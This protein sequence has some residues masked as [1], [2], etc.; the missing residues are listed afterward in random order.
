M[1]CGKVGGCAL[2]VGCGVL[3]V[4]HKMC[5]FPPAHTHV[6]VGF[7]QLLRIQFPFNTGDCGTYIGVQVRLFFDLFDRMYGCCVVFAA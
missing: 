3:R 2:G 5:S 1:K 4:V 7:T 6:S